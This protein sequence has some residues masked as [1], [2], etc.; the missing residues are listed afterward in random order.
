MSQAKELA[1]PAVEQ[2]LE[3]EGLRGNLTDEGYGPL[4]EWAIAAIEGHA[5]QAK[6]AAAVGE[7]GRH[8]REALRK[9]VAAAEGH[10]AKELAGALAFDGKRL[11]GAAKK[12]KTFQPGP[13]ADKNAVQLASILKSGTAG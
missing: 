2:I 5:A 7:Y 12:L 11:G 9:A 4:L 8:V 6:D 3:D 13:E 10:G 1:R